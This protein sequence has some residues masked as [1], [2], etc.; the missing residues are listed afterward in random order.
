MRPHHTKLRRGSPFRFERLPGKTAAALLSAA[1]ALALILPTKVQGDSSTPLGEDQTQITSVQMDQGKVVLQWNVRPGSKHV[2]QCGPSLPPDDSWTQIDEVMPPWEDAIDPGV[3]CRFYRIFLPPKVAINE[4]MY[5]ALDDLDQRG[6]F[7]ELCNCGDVAIDLSG[8]AFVTGIRHTFREGTVLDPG[9]YLVVAKD[10]K[11]IALHY[12]SVR[13]Y[14]PFEGK[15]DNGGE[16]IELVD[17]DGNLVDRVKYNDD[18]PW[19]TTADGLGPS[20]ELVD[21]TR[22]NDIHDN[23]RASTAPAGGTPGAPNSVLDLEI[24]PFLYLHSRAPDEPTSSD[25]VNIQIKVT[26]NGSI[27]SVMLRYDDG[28]GQQI[29]P[30]LDDGEHGDLEAGDSHYGTFIG[31]FDDK[32]TVTYTIE[33]MDDLG[34]VSTHPENAPAE[35]KLI[36]VNDDFLRD[37]LVKINEIMYHPPKDA[38]GLQDAEFVEILNSSTEPVDITGWRLSGGIN[39]SFPEKVL[40]GGKCAVVCLNKKSIAK[41]YDIAE[42]SLFGDFT[43]RLA[44]GGEKINLRNK[45]DVLIDSVEFDD[46]FPWAVAADGYGYSLERIDAV[47]DP[48]SPQTWGAAPPPSEGPKESV[49]KFFQT[50]GTPTTTRLYFYMTGSGECLIDDVELVLVNGGENVLSNSSFEDGATG[51]KKAGNQDFAIQSEA[52]P[53]SAGI[54]SLKIISHGVGTGSG[55]AVYQDGIPVSFSTRYRLSFWAKWLSGTTHLTTRFSGATGG[56]SDPLLE[57]FDLS[58]S[59]L[60]DPFS[61]ASPGRANHMVTSP[62]PPIVTEIAHS[63]VRPQQTD[64]VKI[65]ATVTPLPEIA[66]VS[67]QVTVDAQDTVLPMFDDGVNG[68]DAEADDSTYTATAPSHPPYTIV[69]YNILINGANG[70]LARSPRIQSPGQTHAYYVEGEL[71]R[72]SSPNPV[73]H[74]YIKSS[75]LSLIASYANLRDPAHPN[76]N[77]TVP[78]TFIHD[79]EVYDVQVRHRGSRWCRP[80]AGK[81]SFKIEFPRYHQ[82]D[83]RPDINLNSANHYGFTGYEESLAFEMFRRTGTAAPMTNFARFNI[84]K[85]YHGFYFQIE[86]PGEEFLEAHLGEEGDLFKSMG[87]P[88]GRFPYD[89]GDWRPLES[90]QKYEDVYPRKSLKNESYECLRDVIEGMR[91][92][93][94]TSNSALQDFLEDNF[95][96]DQTLSYIATAAWI[97]VWDE[98][99]HNFFAYRDTRGKWMVLPW[100]TD[101]CFG[102]NGASRSGN[103]IFVGEHG[104]PDNRSGWSN[105]L[106]H[107]IFSVPALKKQYVLKL[108]SLNRRVFTPNALKEYVHSLAPHVWED[109]AEDPF[110]WSRTPEDELEDVEDFIDQRH[111]NIKQQIAEEKEK[112]YFQ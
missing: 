6:E 78:G 35:V 34:Q 11:H 73:Y 79:G 29:V 62:P 91:H 71:D 40:S 58:P 15:L 109:A 4:I 9:D 13:R 97:A 99:F 75:D 83:G 70:E 90:L 12:G 22:N 8:F 74:L 77:K 21:P 111:E 54:S 105:E 10:L 67:L 82:L 50:E 80:W 89:W 20:L 66:S 100:D 18:P 81:R 42:D 31:P 108:E 95:D 48:N 7:V 27:T 37:R 76:W 44:N 3:T 19:D 65:E 86:S 98:A 39:F 112:P 68:G 93:Y 94:N 1:L 102:A 64:E 106:K 59:L 103:S 25:Q 38:A 14:G 61:F 57:S 41:T 28:T 53:G 72:V 17:A 23:W 51:W 45:N 96:M 36:Y 56:V 63:P 32:S 5:N 26:D 30:M 2:L 46:H 87:D 85:R 69:R 88:L 104:N 92:A 52:R 60:T 24:P 43:G 101:G 33:A 16:L 49:W 47:A 107:Y 84:N 55:N 110:G